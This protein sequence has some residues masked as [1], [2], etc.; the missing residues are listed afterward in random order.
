MEEWNDRA[1]R[2][3]ESGVLTYE[4]F[5]HEVSCFSV[6]GFKENSAS[7]WLWNSV[8]VFGLLPVAS[9]FL[10]VRLQD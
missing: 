9:F 3:R 1:F 10:V 8:D 2:N 5:F 6:C 4:L 7:H